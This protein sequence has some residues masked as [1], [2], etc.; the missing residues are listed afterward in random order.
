MGGAEHTLE[1]SEGNNVIEGRPEAPTPSEGRKYHVTV[2][3]EVFEFTDEQGETKHHLKVTYGC[4]GDV[5][6]DPIWLIKAVK[7]ALGSLEGQ[8]EGIVHTA[9]RKRFTWEEIGEALGVTRQSA[10]EKY[11]ID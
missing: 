5:N 8:L 2:D 10:W 1:I 3:A 9:R 6:D 7:T 11:A 4:A